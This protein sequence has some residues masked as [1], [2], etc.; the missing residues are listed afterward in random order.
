MTKGQAEAIMRIAEEA[1]WASQ[2]GLMSLELVPR[3]SEAHIAT[4]VWTAF[5][6][7][8]ER[9]FVI[10]RSRHGYKYPYLAQIE[11]NGVRYFTLLSEDE[12][13]NLA[14]HPFCASTVI[15]AQQANEK[16]PASASGESR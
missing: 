15:P 8:A 7:A 13:R 2:H 9:R 1:H 4:H 3:V 10:Q 12:A 16:A 14:A 11:E 6:E 5:V